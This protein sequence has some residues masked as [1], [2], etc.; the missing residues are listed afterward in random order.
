MNTHTMAKHWNYTA[1]RIMLLL[2]ICLT[3][4]CASSV[5]LLTDIPEAEANEVLSALLD[6]GV[7]AKKLPGK[8]GM[9]S[10]TV[11]QGQV[12]RAITT[13]R[14]EGLPRERYA[15][16]GDVFRK[17]GLISSP[18]EERARYLWALSQELSATIAFIDGVVKARVHVVLPERSSG[19]DPA[20]PSSAAVFIKYR[21]GYNI[22]DSIPQIKRLVANSIPGL[23]SEKVS[24]VLV[25][26]MPKASADGMKPAGAFSSHGGLS[27]GP[28]S[29]A[30]SQPLLLGLLAAGFI[31]LAAL[32]FLG[33]RT[34]GGKLS[35]RLSQARQ[36]KSLAGAEVT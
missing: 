16:M 15:K 36:K 34:W 1:R 27:P 23:V 35:A 10:L 3:A 2:L 29:A 33:W 31:A 19:S 22:D 13:L 25:Q 32:A 20:L 26:S 4:A 7:R 30:E 28:D 21:Q 24:V 12:A 11:E 17:E 8:E 18:L 9:V 5:E 14:A 6:A